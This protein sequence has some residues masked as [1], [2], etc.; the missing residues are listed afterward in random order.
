M[1]WNGSRIEEGA[2]NCRMLRF[3]L[4]LEG[5]LRVYMESSHQRELL[6][7]QNKKVHRHQLSVKFLWTTYSKVLHNMYYYMEES[8][9]LG[10]NPLVESIRHFIWDLCGVF[11]VCH[12]CECRIVQ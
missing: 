10:T 9:L 3:L 1:L 2:Y 11:S 12:L 4:Y 6:T 7:Q 8:V 5:I